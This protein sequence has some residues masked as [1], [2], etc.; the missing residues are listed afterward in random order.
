MAKISTSDP[1]A[2]TASQA[3]DMLHE[4]GLEIDGRDKDLVDLLHSALG[5]IQGRVPSSTFDEA[6]QSASLEQF[7]RAFFL[8][9]SPYVDMLKDILRWF[10]KAEAKKGPHGW[11]LAWDGGDI[12]ELQHFREY[13]RDL[14][15][16][17]ALVELPAISF[18]NCWELIKRLDK[19]PSA[20]QARKLLSQKNYRSLPKWAQ[21]FAYFYEYHFDISE[22]SRPGKSCAA[23]LTDVWNIIR[24]ASAQLDQVGL[25]GRS[26]ACENAQKLNYARTEEDGLAIDSLCMNE[27]DLWLL[28][29]VACAGAI[30]D[31]PTD[32]TLIGEEMDAFLGSMQR[33]TFIAE[34]SIESFTAFLELPLWE[35]R[36]EFYSAWIASRIIEACS[37]HAQDVLHDKGVIA[38]PFKRTEV[39]RILTAIPV[40]TLFSERRSPLSNPKGKGRSENVQPDFGIWHGTTSGDVCDL[41]VEVKHYLHPAKTS[42]T[43]VIEDY[44]NAHPSAT[45]V[46][47]NYGQ[48]GNAMDAVGSDVRSRCRLIGDLRPGQPSAI[49][50]L[51]HLVRRAVGPVFRVDQQGVRG[52]AETPLAVI[53]DRSSSMGLDLDA[54]IHIVR[55]QV[56]AFAASHVG[57][58]TFCTNEYWLAEDG[59]V[60]AAAKH[61]SNSEARFTEILSFFL[62][63][64]PE[65]V[66]VTDDDGSDS[67]DRDKL[68]VHEV[69]PASPGVR[70]LLVA[71]SSQ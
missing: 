67:L 46:L 70:V 51:S 53:L 55:R 54:R 15:A 69:M 28:K 27:T 11:R 39:A 2:T 63:K 44:A 20:Q 43:H 16:C 4:R 12:P 60:D 6:L 71:L 64:F 9:A 61:P 68:R 48:P 23:W 24:C 10:E 7:I 36:H 49:A 65:L 5:T 21:N 13:L 58:A 41:I 57:V 37:A 59:G 38:L 1:A 14:E 50:E 8:S 35:R 3:W 30:L 47:V 66:F 29:L 34:E 62:E 32:Q 45:I 25:S 22:L 19:A 40:R 18:K 26:K 56:D 42:W 33:R 17:T 52:E 31:S